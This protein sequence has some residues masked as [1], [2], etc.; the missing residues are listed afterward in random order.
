MKRTMLDI[1]IKERLGV[2]GSQ[3]PGEVKARIEQTLEGLPQERRRKKRSSISFYK[4]A[5]LAGIML[6]SGSVL[7]A[8]SSTFADA[9]KPLLQS[10]FASMGDKG[11]SERADQK[12]LP[13]LASKEDKGYTLRIHEVQYDGLRLS[14]SYSLS[15]KDGIPQEYYV[16][17][18]FQ[19]DNSMKKMAPGVLNSDSGALWGDNKI[20]IVNYFFD[21]PVPDRLPLQI[22]VPQIAVSGSDAIMKEMVSGNWS[23]EIEAVKSGTIA[24]KTYDDSYTVK[25]DDVQFG[26]TQS[27]TSANAAVW[28]FHLELPRKLYAAHMEDEHY[29]YGL[30]Y[31]VSYGNELKLGVITSSGSSRIA[32]RS[33]PEDHWVEVKDIRMFTEPVPKGVESV[34]VV[35]VLMTYPKTDKGEAYSEK[36]LQQFAVKIPLP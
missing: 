3:I 30:K 20:G 7:A 4:W 36:P 19:L 31:E 13:I 24:E 27:R 15:H 16:K 32:D 26:V 22:N 6:V 17:P 21:R 35:P 29:S 1:R 10:I 23:F 9:M 18:A 28:N 2:Q 5:W 14:F 25:Q 34:T 12:E 8:S 11:V 33:L